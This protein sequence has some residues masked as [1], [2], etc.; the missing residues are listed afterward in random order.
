[1]E[2]VCEGDTVEKLLQ[3]YNLTLATAVAKCQVAAKKH[4]SDIANLRSEMFA[5][6]GQP[7]QMTYHMVVACPGCG[8]A[9]HEGTHNQEYLIKHMS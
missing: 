4:T 9:I 2:G 7:Y 8:S 3:E 5:A 1:M 6:V